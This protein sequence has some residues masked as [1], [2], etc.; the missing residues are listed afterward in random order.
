MLIWTWNF[1]ILETRHLKSY[2]S[3]KFN[4]EY[5][6]LMELVWIW[7]IVHIRNMAHTLQRKMSSSLFCFWISTGLVAFF[8]KDWVYPNVYNLV[9]FKKTANKYPSLLTLRNSIL[10]IEGHS[11]TPPVTFYKGLVMIPIG[12]KYNLPGI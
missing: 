3:F 8:W 1:T 12:T 6:F 9:K 2:N 10:Y 7:N 5:K 11:A 4:V